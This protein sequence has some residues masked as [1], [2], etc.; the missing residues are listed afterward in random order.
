MRH[1]DFAFLAHNGELAG[2][3]A[4]HDWSL[5][6][7]GCV[8]TWPQSLKTTIALV[9]QSPVPIVTLWGE[10]GIMIYN[11]AYSVFA[12]GRHPQLLGSKVREGWPEVAD[13]NDNVM[14]V[15]L[16]G[17]TLAYT[18]QKLSLQRSGQL[19]PAWM[20]LDYSPIIGE[21]GKPIAVMAIVVE[22][23]SKVKAERAIR[24]ERKRLK[25]MFEQ[26]PGFMAML[27][28]P[29]HRFEL[30]NE[31]YL[32][33]IGNRDVIGLPLL[34][35]LP[36]LRGQGF[37]KLLDTVTESSEAYV[38]NS[39]PV[40]LERSAGVVEERYLDF[41]YQPIL[42][43]ERNNL[44]IFVQGNDVTEQK[45]AELAL[46]H[47]TAV[48]SVLNKLGADLAAERDL[49]KVV[50]MITDAGVAMTGAKFGA[51]FYN[52][53]DEKGESYMLYAL[54]GVPRESFSSFPM[55]RATSVFQPTFK[56]EG[57]I[58]S[59]NILTD[60]RYGHSGPY[61]GMP[62]GH[63]PVRSYLAVPVI[64]RSGEVIGGLF[65]GHPKPGLFKQDHEDLVISA[66]GLAA[67]GMDNA[68]LF[69]AAELE[70]AERKRAEQELQ[71]VNSNLEQR[72]ASEITERMKMEET[73]R[74]SQKMEALGQLT[75][76]VAH[77]F[78][79]LLQV[80][81]G[82]LQLLSGDVQGNERAQK[83]IENALAGVNRGSKLASQLLAFGRRQPL[84]PKVVNIG[85]FVTGIED[86]LR[87]TLGEAIEIET[88]RSGGLWNA[89][90]DPTQIENALLNLAINARDAMDGAGKLT[91]EVGNAFLDDD[92]VRQ[93]DDVEAGQYV[94]LAV[95]DTGCGM[96]A[97]ILKQVFEPFF[98]T[99][100]IDKGT[101]LGLSM[102]YGFVKQSGGHV[103]IYSEVGQGTTI[104][105]YFP[106]IRQTEDVIVEDGFGPVTG[107]SE[108]IL[109]AEDDDQVRNTVVELL[110]DLGYRVLKA[111]D[112][113]GALT[114][115]E[116]GAAVDLLFTDVV[117]PGPLRSTDLVRQVKERSPEIAVLFTSGYTENSIVHGGRLDPGVELLSK[118]YT[119]ESL[120][121]KIRHVL[122]NHRQRAEAI[123]RLASAPAPSPPQEKTFYR[124]LLVED[125][126]LIRMS[127]SDILMELGH[128]VEEASSAEQ[129][130]AILEVQPIAILITDLGL[131]GMSGA[132]LAATVRK[133]YPNMG[134]VFAT[135][136]DQAPKLDD[137]ARTALLKKPFGTP[138][139][140]RAIESLGL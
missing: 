83:R 67:I 116:S 140:T 65:F 59:D 35:A 110:G 79:N 44:G 68:R 12:G 11:D 76:G 80:V 82:N 64:S 105:L 118:P 109:V 36:E 60:P 19:E 30:A 52:V 107:G 121:R 70:I 29:E 119:R 81:S 77:D 138:E 15:G 132:E 13:F 26:A 63:L 100:P 91:I 20:N 69:Q 14:K 88:S 61:H 39:T 38:G 108:T 16:A 33:L 78:N 56:G 104:K 73:L 43:E 37:E 137:P 90:V 111:R 7:I 87:R 50:Q 84:E 18:D 48:L 23:T 133:Q 3:I 113:A 92:Y 124:V 115:I 32:R 6:S 112:A 66:A 21:S 131:P 40:R 85:R 123:Q 53:L 8:T 42:D 4:A 54:S 62:S 34:E 58:R 96:D 136:Q 22:T 114:V 24:G 10:D 106:R 74:Q 57:V 120:A 46:R 5:T 28:G 97:S 25:R 71:Q 95:T 129:A 89:L 9:L 94:M 122:N 27:T 41:I 55:P 126:F 17:G 49:D 1:D 135:G 99:K 2:L 45:H 102:V 75:G 128:T 47:E 101:G 86:M 134:I 127:T 98:S 51:F 117:M 125:D 72:V 93:N 31:A 139:I 103:K 130:L